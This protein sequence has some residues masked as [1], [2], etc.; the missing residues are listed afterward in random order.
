MKGIVLYVGSVI[1]KGFK[2][3]CVQVGVGWSERSNVSVGP[4]SMGSWTGDKANKKLTSP[5]VKTLTAALTWIKWSE[6]ETQP[7]SNILFFW[8]ECISFFRKKIWITTSHKVHLS[9]VHAFEI[10]ALCFITPKHHNCIT[11]KFTLSHSQMDFHKFIS[12]SKR[13]STIS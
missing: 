11:I 12:T 9:F 6:L 3:D 2:C 8:C 5:A 10:T 13:F 1:T 4:K 7:K